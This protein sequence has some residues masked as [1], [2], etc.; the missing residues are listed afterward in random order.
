[1]AGKSAK[2]GIAC[3]ADVGEGL[4]AL[5]ALVLLLVLLLALALPS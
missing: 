3:E 4:H 5:V 2:V 1:M